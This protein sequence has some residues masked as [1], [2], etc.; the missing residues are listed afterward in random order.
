MSYSPCVGWD[1]L[2]SPRTELG[3]KLGW[4]C[5]FCTLMSA[6][7]CNPDLRENNCWH[8]GRRAAAVAAVA[9]VAGQH[10]A[11]A[12]QVQRGRRGGVGALHHLQP[13]ITQSLGSEPPRESP[14]VQAQQA[15]SSACHCDASDF[16]SYSATL[17]KTTLIKAYLWEPGG[18]AAGRL[19]PRGPFLQLLSCQL[20]QHTMSHDTCTGPN[21]QPVRVSAK[22][23]SR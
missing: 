14:V 17:E 9:A 1:G 6:D 19:R 12:A 8:L 10:G 16:D 13:A 3:L 5:R 22:E 18:Q 4:G 20:Q 2:S 7:C 11:G 23:A 21:A 15:C